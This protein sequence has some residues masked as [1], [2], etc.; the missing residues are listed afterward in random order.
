M[1]LLERVRAGAAVVE[2]RARFVR[3]DLERGARLAVELADAAATPAQDPA[4]QHPP[5]PAQDP[6]HH[7]LATPESTLAYVVTLGAVNF[8]SGWFPHLKKRPG[9]SGYFTIA[10]ALKER[11]D[12]DGPF[13]AR[14]LCAID[15]ADCASLFGQDLSSPEVGELMDL[16]ARALRDL[17]RLLD[18]RYHGRFEELIRAADESAERLA[19][20]LTEMPF[21]RDV[22]WYE[23]REI[24]FYKRA[25]LTAADLAAAFAGESFGRFGDLSALTLFADNLVPHVLR[26]EGVLVYDAS[27][28]SRIDSGE[29]IPPASPEEVEIRACAVHAVEQMA[30]AVTLPEGRLSPQ[31]LDYLLWTRGQHPDLKAHPRHRT[32]TVYY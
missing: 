30:G 22:A 3:V 23:D 4:H 11:F 26:C 21:Y 14:A 8:G 20:L 1:D 32:R 7:Q 31:R 17:G 27:L 13:T 28:A 9:C 12:E 24:A 25:Q 16:F 29:L 10:H 6:A 15:R 2:Q 19:S 18:E 5:T